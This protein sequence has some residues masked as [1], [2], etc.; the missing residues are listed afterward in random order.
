MPGRRPPNEPT[1]VSAGRPC[2]ESQ[3]LMRK[4]DDRLTSGFCQWLPLASEHGFES[5]GAVPVGF[6]AA[7]TGTRHH[8][9]R[10]APGRGDG[11]VA[12][13]GGRVRRAGRLAR[14]GHQLL[15]AL[16]RWQ[17]GMSP[18]TA[19]EH[20]R[21]ARALR[22]LPLIKAAFDAGRLSYAKVRALTRIAAPDCEAPLLESRRRRPPRRPSGSAAPGGASRTTPASPPGT[23]GRRTGSPSPPGP[24]TRAI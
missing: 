6:L 8:H 2:A 13:A 12:A 22:G 15:G 20:V 16:D 17:C 24:T 9:R 1:S 21:V 18:T 10:G 7:G 11:G 4:R 3:A 19:R 14:R 23:G 5:R